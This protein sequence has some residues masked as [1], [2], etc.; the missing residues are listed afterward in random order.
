MKVIH[1]VKSLFSYEDIEI[2]KIIWS[3]K[4]DI[5]FCK[6]KDGIK[7]I[8][9]IKRESKNYDYI[10]S[11]PSSSYWQNIKGFDH[12]HKILRVIP[13]YIP[14][15]IVPRLHKKEQKK[16]NKMDRINHIYKSYR[17]S[18]RFRYLIKNKNNLKIL[19]LDDLKTTG[20]TLHEAC[21]TIQSS[22]QCTIDCLTIAYE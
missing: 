18:F 3:L 13:N 16:L 6:S 22:V 1:K 21:S 15:S 5:N 11:I 20:L 12:M 8:D 14:Y 2:K 4:K 19:I 9:I 10:I 7:I 17:L